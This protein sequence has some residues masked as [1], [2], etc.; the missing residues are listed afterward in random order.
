MP[1]GFW[2]HESPRQDEVKGEWRI[3][4]I[5]PGKYVNKTPNSN[6]L[7]IFSQFFL[8]FNI[9]FLIMFF[10]LF[11]PFFFI[12]VKR[13]SFLSLKL[14]EKRFQNWKFWKNAWNRIMRFLVKPLFFL[15]CLFSFLRG[16]LKYVFEKIIWKNLFKKR[17]YIYYLKKALFKSGAILLKHFSVKVGLRKYK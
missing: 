2:K 16:E 8:R 13:W 7:K 3:G 14:L 4:A 6:G 9:G 15:V 12:S 17:N 5:Q 1:K 11:G 10:F